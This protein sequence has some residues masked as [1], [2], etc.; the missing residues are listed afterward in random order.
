[1]SQADFFD[2]LLTL[3][4]QAGIPFMVAG[5]LGST[6]H[7]EPRTT[8]DIDVI[9]APT[10][11]QL[12]DFLASLGSRYYVSPQAAQEAFRQRSMFNVIDL[13]TGFKADLI[14][15]KDRPFSLEEFQRRRP[16][17]LL[18]KTAPVASPED[19]ILSKL[20]WSKITQSDRQLR[21]ALGVA[22]VQGSRL[23]LAYL[24]WWAPQLGVAD[25]LE[26]LLAEAERFRENA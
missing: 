3:L 7:G 22:V 25:R 19:I 4:E 21:D 1:M 8:N 10:P 14:L 13:E 18:E 2:R 12:R 15:R 26:E 11:E 24:R 17:T 23:D 16:V 9:L 20:E 6:A 5:S